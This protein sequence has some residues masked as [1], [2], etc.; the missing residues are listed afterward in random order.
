MANP[1]CDRVCLFPYFCPSLPSSK[2]S[3]DHVTEVCHGIVGVL[4]YASICVRDKLSSDCKRIELFSHTCGLFIT[5][6]LAGT[7]AGSLDGTCSSSLTATDY[8]TTNAQNLSNR[9]K[10]NEF[11]DS[12]TSEFVSQCTGYTPSIVWS[13]LEH[14]GVHEYVGQSLVDVVDWTTTGAVDGQ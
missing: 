13:G 8:T 9:W 4:S 14:S 5:R 3:A 1:V 10:V 7:L 11:A 12:T 6:F 2:S